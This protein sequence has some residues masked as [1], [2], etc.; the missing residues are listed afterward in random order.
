M[1]LH[2]LQTSAIILVIAATPL[3]KDYIKRSDSS[4]EKAIDKLQD[5]ADNQMKEFL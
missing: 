5:R 3:L 2:T 4:L 1:S